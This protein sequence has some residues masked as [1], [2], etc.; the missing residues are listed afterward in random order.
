[1]AIPS[2][3]LAVVRPKG[4]V[5]K[6]VKGHYYVVKRTSKYVKGRRVPVDLGIIGSIVD[7]KYVERQTPVLNY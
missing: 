2:E 5:V 3:I 6:Y 1:M 7:G 4:T